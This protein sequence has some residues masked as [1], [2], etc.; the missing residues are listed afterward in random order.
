MSR[1]YIVKRNLWVALA[2]AVSAVPALVSAEAAISQGFTSDESIRTGA[3]VSSVNDEKR[4]EPA[5]T[6]NGDKLLGVA[7]KDSLVELSN[8]STQVQVVTSGLTQTFVSDINGEVEVGDPITVSPLVGVGMKATESGYV[9]GTARANFS[10]ISDKQQHIV[11][12]K[13]G[14]DK[15]V[16]VALLPVQVNVIYFS[17]MDDEKS[18]LPQFLINIAQSVAGKDVSVARI[19]IAML[20]LMAG[21]GSIGVVLYSSVRSSILSIG[22]NPLAAS[23]VHKSLLE[24][25][26]LSLG[27]LLV[28]LGAVYLILVV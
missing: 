17:K 23:A 24:V 15:Q 12:D 20:V 25:S 10:E 11:K 2:M 13:S 5:S 7:G 1:K 3:L 4:I 8:T 6:D 27:I 22:R 18:I 28:M 9:V 19:L 21:I 16:N 26:L 14:N